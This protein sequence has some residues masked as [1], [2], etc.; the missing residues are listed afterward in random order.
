MMLYLGENTEYWTALQAYAED[1]NW[2]M[3]LILENAK[4]RAKVSKYEA[5]FDELANYRRELDE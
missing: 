2:N 3:N 1:N 4:L 5:T